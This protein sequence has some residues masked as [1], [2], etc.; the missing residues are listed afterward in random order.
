MVNPLKNGAEQSFISRLEHRVNVIEPSAAAGA[1]VSLDNVKNKVHDLADHE[2]SGSTS[3][4]LYSH[5]NLKGR[6]S[7]HFEII[8]F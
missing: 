5:S 6:E 3:N 2:V 8:I 4:L 7:L 1:P